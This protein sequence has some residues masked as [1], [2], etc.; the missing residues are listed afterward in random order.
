MLKLRIIPCLDIKNGRVVK[1]VNFE[2]L[3]DAGNPVSQAQFY[4]QENADEICL[5]DI[6]ASNENRQTIIE[7]V[8]AVAKNCFI[9]ITVGGG[10][11]T[12]ESFSHL[13]KNGAD[14]VS[15]N[16]AAVKNCQL[17]ANCANIF[18]NQAVVVAI[19]VKINPNFSSGYEVFTNGGTKPANIDAVEWAENVV[20]L[21]AGE[22]L[23]T[24]MN[25]DGTKE[26]YDL[27]I[28][29]KIS[30]KVEVPI[31]ASGGVGSLQHL[32]QGI[33]CGASAVLA[34]SIFHFRHFSINQAKQ[35]LAN[36]GF[37]VRL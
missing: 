37:A 34:A 30:Q 8:E 36:Y 18:G 9:P 5:L 13:I 25:K 14:K 24:S 28:I 23:L 7:V 16:S 6:T 35:Y 15:I 17:I 4:Y 26:G 20:K 2:N 1:G 33:N 27:E 19:D 3:V 22:I 31:I 32:A 10:V 11:A 29:K 12:V 21:G